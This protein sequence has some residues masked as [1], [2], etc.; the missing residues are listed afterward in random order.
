MTLNSSNIPVFK[1]FSNATG[2]ELPFN[3]GVAELYYYENLLSETVRMTITVV[4]TGKGDSGTTASEQIKLTGTEKVHIELEDSQ[5]Q[6]ISFKTTANELHITGRERITDKLKD[7]EILELVSNE[8]LKNES[9]RVDKRYDGKISDSLNK[10]LK[11]VL[12]TQKKLDIE[13]TK[14]TRSFIGTMKKPFWFIMWLAGQSIRENT[15]ALGLS[16]GYFFFET[17]SGYKFKSIDT[18][19]GQNPVKKYIYNNTTSTVIPTGYDAKILEYDFVDS[20]D[21]KDQLTMGTFNTSV[22]LFNS[23]ESSFNCNPLDI[24][25]QESA[26]TAAGTEYGKNLFKDFISKPSRFFTGSESIGGLK[27]IDEAKELDTD[28]AKYLSSA[29]ARYNQA[30]TVKANIT[31]FG[32]YS[33]E[34]GQLIFCDFPEQ[35]TKTNTTANPRMSGIYM[36]SA[37]C[38]RIDPQQQCFTSLELIRDSYGRKPMLSKKQEPT[39]TG[40]GQG[41]NNQGQGIF[42]EGQGVTGKG[43]TDADIA[44]ALEAE[45][46][47]AESQ[48]HGATADYWEAIGEGLQSGASYKELGLNQAEIDYLEGRRDQ[49]PAL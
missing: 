35:S 26:I 14:N 31:I 20:A 33:L 4:D 19:F 23:F 17:K 11:D 41:V 7:I 5:E 45:A 15:S 21:M 38:H 47:L 2:K 49:P 16:S 32:D 18:L 22:N 44:D 43:V 29:T 42:A 40:V 25:T 34:V 37:L 39:P 10:I 8:Y 9:V 28:K 3:G 13:P 27:P 30:Y 6:K 46:N 36:I 48:Y 12:K 1:I 24:T